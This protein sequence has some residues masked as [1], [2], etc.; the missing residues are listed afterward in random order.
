MFDETIEE[1]KE[2][3][4]VKVQWYH[5]VVSFLTAD[6]VIMTQILI[7]MLMKKRCI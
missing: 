3:Q 5:A 6:T 7:I 2:L 1:I 4:K